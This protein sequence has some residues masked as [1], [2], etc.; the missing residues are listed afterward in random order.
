M[1]ATAAASSARAARTIA[2]GAG[3][4][5]GL[6]A[7]AVARPDRLSDDRLARPQPVDRRGHGAEPSPAVRVTSPKRI[8]YFWPSAVR[9]CTSIEMNAGTR[10]TGGVMCPSVSVRSASVRAGSSSP[11]P[12][13]WSSGDS[14]GVLSVW[15]SGGC[16]V[17]VSA[18]APPPWRSRSC[19]RRGRAPSPARR[20]HRTRRCPA[21][22]QEPVRPHLRVNFRREMP[23]RDS[24]ESHNADAMDTR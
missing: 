6:D 12:P 8:A 1:A 17:T 22:A 5:R 21:R 4:G 19:C 16:S 11:A 24:A 9:S 15:L 18:G 10:T 23:I 7:D 3:L 14:A 13:G 20:R 2:L